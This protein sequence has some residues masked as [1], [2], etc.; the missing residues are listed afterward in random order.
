MKKSE[1]ITFKADETLLAAM[2][3]IVNRSEFIRAAVLSAL[4]NI[5]PLC[6][7]SGTLTPRQREHWETFALSHSI[8]ECGKCHEIHL[9]CK[10][11]PAPRRNSHRRRT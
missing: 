3:G 10:S 11:D 4:E 1:I 7:G 5:C 8:A 9:V 2:K 6:R